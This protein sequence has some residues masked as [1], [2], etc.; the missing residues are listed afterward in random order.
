VFEEGPLFTSELSA[1]LL[2]STDDIVTIARLETGFDMC[3][4]VRSRCVA[5][6][7]WRILNESLDLL[8][9][10]TALL[11]INQRLPVHFDHGNGVGEARVEL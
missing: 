10:R 11:E 3:Q 7:R 2:C 8:S 4:H 1:P 9:D 5:G 6:P